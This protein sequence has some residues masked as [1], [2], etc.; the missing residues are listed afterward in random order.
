MPTRREV[1]ASILRWFAGGSL[2]YIAWKFI[3]GKAAACIEVS[4]S[5]KPQPGEV[6]FKKGVFIVGL[7]KGIKA[8]SSCCPHLGCR[9]SYNASMGRFECPCHG[10]RFTLAGQ[11]LE[12]PT[13]KNMTGLDLRSDDKSGTY[14]VILG[15]GEK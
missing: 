7:D 8:L 6:I 9:L 5:S 14:K 4:F 11:K 1:C 12:G 3:R 13:Q 10:S 2:F 15:L